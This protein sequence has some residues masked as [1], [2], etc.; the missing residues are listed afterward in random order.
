MMKILQYLMSHIQSQIHQPVINFQHKIN[1]KIESFL[2]MEKILSKIKVCLINSISIKLP[3]D[4]PS[5]I[6]VYAQGRAM[7]ELILKI[8]VP[9]LIK[10]DLWFQNLK[11]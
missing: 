3:V 7:I 2:S 8:F 10:S 1:K 6:S 4:N 11:Y 9:Y 5:S